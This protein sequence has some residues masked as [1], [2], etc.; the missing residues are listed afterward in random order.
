[1]V[2]TGISYVP[3]FYIQFLDLTVEKLLFG[4]IRMAVI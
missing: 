4:I 3:P 2:T 1:M